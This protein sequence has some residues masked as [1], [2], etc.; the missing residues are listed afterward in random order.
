MIGQPP[1]NCLIERVLVLIEIFELEVA[2]M[3]RRDEVGMGAGQGQG[4]GH[5]RKKKYPVP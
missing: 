3:F 2:G 1:I 5:A 4:Q